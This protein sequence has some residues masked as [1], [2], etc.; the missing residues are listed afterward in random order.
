MGFGRYG[1]CQNVIEVIS[2]VNS[3]YVH[4]ITFHFIFILVNTQFLLSPF[5]PTDFHPAYGI[6]PG[7]PK[8]SH[9]VSNLLTYIQIQSSLE[10]DA[11]ITST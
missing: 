7:F 10:M 2:E 11:F 3:P 1:S 5:D 4:L 9:F 8:K 6:S